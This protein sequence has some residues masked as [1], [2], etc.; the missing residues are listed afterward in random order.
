MDEYETSRELFSEN[1]LVEVERTQSSCNVTLKEENDRLSY[2]VKIKGIPQQSVVIKTDKLEI[3]KTVFRGRYGECKR[4]DYAIITGN[5]IIFIEMKLSGSSKQEVVK[6]FKGAI[7]FL[8][9]CKSISTEFLSN[10]NYLYGFEKYFVIIGNMSMTKY[11]KPDIN[12]K[13]HTSPERM[14]VINNT[15]VINFNRL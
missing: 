10:T 3:P 1:I 8:E 11:I 6:Q 2:E 14:L 9:Y 13:T 7:C 12:N 15:T 5:K 4:S